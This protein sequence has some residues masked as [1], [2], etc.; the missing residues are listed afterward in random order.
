MALDRDGLAR[1]LRAQSGVV[2]RRQLR[3]LGAAKHD[4]ERLVRRRELVAVGRSVFVDHT[5]AL[6]WLQRAWAATLAA[7]PAALCLG[8][9]A[10]TPDEAGPIHLAID[11]SRRVAPLPGVRVH[12]VVALADKV[13]WTASPPR[14]RPEHN[15]LELAH[16]ARSEVEVVRVLTDEVNARRTT[17]ER[18]RQASEARP[19]LRRRAFIGDVLA[20]L[21]AGACSVLE[22]G[23]LERVARPHGLPVADHQ[24]VRRV[25]GRSEYRDLEHVALG[26]VI[27][28]DGAT[29]HDSWVASG[30][31]ADRDLDDLAADR[32]TVRLRWWQ[33]Y[34]RP[35][36][37]A[38]R[39]ARVLQSRGWQGQA[40]A[41]GPTC[42][43][44]AD[45][46]AAGVPGAPGTP[47]TP[48][49]S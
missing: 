19:R 26:V 16:R 29:G 45:A 49:S 23:Y 31:D 46:S 43:L 40:S 25:A 44:A 21:A 11:E 42:D 13:R 10:P 30:R 15:A 7:G 12:R 22:R 6:T 37:T 35:C 18:L 38:V 33:V 36:A 8:S 9:A 47:I 27:E 14:L 24:V 3:E 4:V 20:D 32:I 48:A 5:G 1:V 17:P 41:C 2:T 28:L 39:L 34:E